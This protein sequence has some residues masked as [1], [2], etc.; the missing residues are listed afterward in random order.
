MLLQRRSNGTPSRT[1][2][3][4]YTALYGAAKMPNLEVAGVS[5]GK[6][7]GVSYTHVLNKGGR[8]V[9]SPLDE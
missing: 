2:V 1:I 3:N 9:V 5:P 6:K 7:D 4:V 8:G